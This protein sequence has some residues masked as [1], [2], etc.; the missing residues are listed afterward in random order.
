MEDPI[1]KLHKIDRIMDAVYTATCEIMSSGK[2]AKGSR[3]QL[4]RI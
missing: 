3:S 4:V 2:K 1:E